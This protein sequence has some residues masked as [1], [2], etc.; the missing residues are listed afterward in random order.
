MGTGKFENLATAPRGEG[1][2]TMTMD[3]R[4]KILSMG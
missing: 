2:I 4:R 3:T 1:I